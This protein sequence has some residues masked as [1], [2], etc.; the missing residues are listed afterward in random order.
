MVVVTEIRL[1]SVVVKPEAVSLPSVVVESSLIVE[2]ETSLAT[3]LVCLDFVLTLEWGVCL[4][5]PG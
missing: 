2:L 3:C 4:P 5:R 1:V